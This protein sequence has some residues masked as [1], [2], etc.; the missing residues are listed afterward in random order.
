MS[1]RQVSGAHAAPIRSTPQK[2]N[3]ICRQIT[4]GVSFFFPFMLTVC[5]GN[6][7]HEEPPASDTEV[8]A[9]SL[10][11]GRINAANAAREGGGVNSPTLHAW[12]WRGQQ[13]TPFVQPRAEQQVRN[14]QYI[15]STRNEEIRSA[16]SCFRLSHEPNQGI[17]RKHPDYFSSPPCTHICQSENFDLFV[18]FYTKYGYFPRTLD[19]ILLLRDILLPD[20][21][22]VAVRFAS[23]T[24]ELGG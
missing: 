10:D 17:G 15:Q 18:I 12:A 14:E 13:M 9:G 3:R 22:R 1:A 2:G 4:R 20:C 8:S 16:Y 7:R 6:R 21:E 11:A 24:N 23:G 19:S 5:H